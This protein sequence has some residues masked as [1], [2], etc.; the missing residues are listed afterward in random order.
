[1]KLKTIL[2]ILTIVILTSCGKSEAEIKAEKEVAEKR[3]SDSLAVIKRINDSI[4][5]ESDLRFT[6]SIQ[7]ELDALK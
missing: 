6:D 5:H 7:K 3:V 1:M 2:S 4:K